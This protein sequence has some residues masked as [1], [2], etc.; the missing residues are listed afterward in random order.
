MP[1]CQVENCQIQI[2]PAL[3]DETLAGMHAFLVECAVGVLVVVF[4]WRSKLIPP[5]AR[6]WPPAAG[7]IGNIHC[8]P[9]PPKTPIT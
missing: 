1:N 5:E 4:V 2:S 9:P 8:D 3:V 6:L 7:L